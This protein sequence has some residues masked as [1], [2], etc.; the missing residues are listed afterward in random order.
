MS[1]TIPSFRR[2]IEIEKLYWS[3][4]KKLLPGKKD[5]KAF[6][7]IFESARLYASY[8]SNAV[9]PIVFESVIM[10]TLFHNYKTL[11]E[12]NKEDDKANEN[13]VINEIKVLAEDKPKGK[14]LFDSICK[15]WKGSSRV[16][17]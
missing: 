12:I 9:N 8:L 16:L 5:K 4:Y 7:G 1:R 11:L 17:T 14:I 6:D 15:K 13:V 2:L 3:P 10:A